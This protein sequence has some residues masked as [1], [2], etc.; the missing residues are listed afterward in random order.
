MRLDYDVERDFYYDQ[1]TRLAYLAWKEAPLRRP[2]EEGLISKERL[3]ELKEK[4]DPKTLVDRLNGWY[5]QTSEPYKVPK[6]QEEA[7]RRIE[8]LQEAAKYLIQQLDIV[9][10]VN[11]CGWE[12][13]RAY[14]E[15]LTKL[16]STL[17]GK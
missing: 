5:S 2:T 17:E 13:S 10:G 14:Y 9:C 12:N 11:F 6:I 3:K 7:A 8:E 16:R 4:D 1:Y 15:S